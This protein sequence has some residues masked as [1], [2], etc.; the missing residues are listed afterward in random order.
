MEK[1]NGLTNRID[2][3]AYR[4]MSAEQQQFFLFDTLCRVDERT[5]SM[6]E[7][8][9]AKWV[10]TYFKGGVTLVLTGVLATI[11]GF[12]GIHTKG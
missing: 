4:A 12:V 5:A 11:L 2:F 10:E 8:Y 6:E 7:K 9:A 1:E 3:A